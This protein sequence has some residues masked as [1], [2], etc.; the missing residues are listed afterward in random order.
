MVK[1]L[2]GVIAGFALTIWYVAF[3]LNYH[4]DS[5]IAVNIVI[6][7]ATAL[8]TAIHFDTVKKQRKDRVWEI[9][10]GVLLTLLELVSQA[11]E[12]TEFSLDH[13]YAHEVG[14]HPNNEIWGK[15]KLQANLALNVYGSLMS[16]ELFQHIET[17]KAIDEQI[18]DEVFNED[19]D[20]LDAHER[21]LENL[22]ALQLKLR[23]FILQMA[24]LST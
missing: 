11:I 20:H 22:Q 18:H 9:N 3:D 13:E 21:S 6:A 24:G 1:F 17:S 10:K 2:I 14:H 12:E 4:F 5:N 23:E 15:L 19:L 16:K 7:S 8:A